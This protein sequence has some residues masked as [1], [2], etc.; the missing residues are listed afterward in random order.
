M[1]IVSTAWP[2][3]T[4]VVPSQYRVQRHNST[5]RHMP[6]YEIAPPASCCYHITSTFNIHSVFDSKSRPRRNVFSAGG[7]YL[8]PYSRI[9]SLVLLFHIQILR[10]KSVQVFS[11]IKE[12]KTLTKVKV[13]TEAGDLEK[14]DEGESGDGGL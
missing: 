10:S 6:Q 4:P 5:C 9:P 2:P 3:G 11:S 12:L 8:H 1:Y 14:S 7:H 13:T